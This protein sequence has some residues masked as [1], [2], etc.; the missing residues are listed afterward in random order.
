MSGDSGFAARMYFGEKL[1]LM[2]RVCFLWEWSLRA[3]AVWRR[4][5]RFAQNDGQQKPFDVL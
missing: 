4:C 5:C 1:L 2:K 3:I